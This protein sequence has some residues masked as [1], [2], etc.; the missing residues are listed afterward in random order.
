MNDMRLE[1]AVVDGQMDSP[2][3]Y[4]QLKQRPPKPGPL[5]RL[6]SRLRTVYRQMV[7]V[8]ARL[9][10]AVHRRLLAAFSS[11]H[12]ESY[13]QCELER[14]T[15]LRTASLTLGF[16]HPI[17][18]KSVTPWKKDYAFVP[19]DALAF[20]SNPKN[21]FIYIH[22]LSA[23][24]AL[25][26]ASHPLL[27]FLKD[28]TFLFEKL[29][30]IPYHGPDAILY[31]SQFKWTNLIRPSYNLNI[32]IAATCTIYEFEAPAIY[33]GGSLNFG[34][35]LTDCYPKFLAID[36]ASRQ[37]SELRS[38]LPRLVIVYCEQGELDYL[39]RAHPDYKFVNFK[40]YDCTLITGLE[41]YTTQFV[42]FPVACHLL[43]QQFQPERAAQADTPP[44]MGSGRANA[45]VFLSRRGFSR[46]RVENE[47]EL[48]GMLET[49]GF[50]ILNV[51][52]YS[53]EG[54]AVKLGN[55]DMIV[56]GFGAHTVNAI[57]LPSGSTF[58]EIVPRSFDVSHGWQY[59]HSLFMSAGIH[60]I[61]FV[62]DDSIAS[63]KG[64]EDGTG[65]FDWEGYVNIDVVKQHLISVGAS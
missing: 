14:S 3:R 13:T 37:D 9:A 51:K 12:S 23:S 48:I 8:G 16:D 63:I 47:D 22:K 19:A 29:H 5:G 36:Q 31:L 20:H 40:G 24:I 33:I 11:L 41:L 10:R 25:F 44:P 57:F 30:E 26:P 45:K 46:R 58:F 6:R 38:A 32:D 1:S 4:L 61:R 56:S 49:L 39:K 7:R 34:H 55:Y 52:D 53:I 2:E 35:F 42:P 64:G 60:Y 21:S 50:D 65:I 62:A 18:S 17:W 28:K 54:L 59:N 15:R 27:M 43:R